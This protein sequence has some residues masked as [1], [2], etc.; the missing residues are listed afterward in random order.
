MRYE[1]NIFINFRS[2]F[3]EVP[4]YLS[5][6]YIPPATFGPAENKIYYSNAPKAFYIFS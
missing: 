5:K 2:F 3:L 6:I 1:I 4:L